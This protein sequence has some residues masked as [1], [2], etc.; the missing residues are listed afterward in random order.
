[1]NI[2]L[3]WPKTE[4]SFKILYNV[5][6]IVLTIRNKYLILI[7]LLKNNK[8]FL[9]NHSVVIMKFGK[10]HFVNIKEKF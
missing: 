1:M 10:R 6:I 9:K 3:T 2:K 4:N 7:L 5:H 8:I